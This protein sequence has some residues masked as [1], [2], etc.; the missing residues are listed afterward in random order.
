MLVDEAFRVRV[1]AKP[2]AEKWQELCATQLI[3]FQI[4]HYLFSEIPILKNQN[5]GKNITVLI[6]FVFEDAS[7]VKAKKKTY[8]SVSCCLDTSFLLENYTTRKIH[9]KLLQQPV[10]YILHVFTLSI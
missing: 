3:L 10:W 1:I 7:F 2:W 9:M 4:F 5:F 8:F 6:Y